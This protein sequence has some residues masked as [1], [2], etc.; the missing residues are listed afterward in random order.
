MRSVAIV[1]SAVV[2]LSGCAT[3][4]QEQGADAVVPYQHSESAQVIVQAT[5]D[6][7]GPFDFAVDTGASIS[8]AFDK[9]CGRAELP[10]VSEKFTTIQGLVA[11]GR[12][13]LITLDELK[14][15][16]VTWE[17]VDVAVLPS[18][19][20]ACAAIEGILGTDL[21]SRYAI[22]VFADEGALRLYPPEIV[23]E[24]SYQGWASIPLKRMPI[25]DAG[26]LLYAIDLVIFDRRVRAIFDLG[27]GLNMINWPAARYLDL[28]VP[29]SVS[30]ETLKGAVDTKEI[31]GAY[32]VDRLEAGLMNW[33]DVEFLIADLEVFEALGLDQQPIAIVGSG[34]FR[35]RDFI[36]DFRR[37]RL[38]VRRLAD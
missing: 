30:R 28:R 16:A 11:S 37:S 3:V 34:F 22:G 21:L 8:V 12:Y 32:T 5:V 25:G 36:I 10:T 31:T 19:S 20:P 27:A 26:A 17:D 13:P 38:L 9:L 2:A 18:D 14:V 24:R 23:S 15:G 1:A 7:H 33:F 29:R 35:K 6:G 4:L